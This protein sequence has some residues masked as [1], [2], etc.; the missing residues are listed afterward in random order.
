MSEIESPNSH[1]LNLL[2]DPEKDFVLQFV[3]SSGSLKE[4]AGAYGVS[5]PTL[6]ARLDRL[7]A[8]LHQAIGGRARDPVSELLA[9][10]IE[11]GELA[12][13]T[14]R[15]IQDTHRKQLEEVANSR[16]VTGE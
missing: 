8:R 14:A 1:P 16:K 13:S 3:L 12:V 4:M 5:Y 15:K 9:A 11:R 7:I 10:M 6:R 2:T